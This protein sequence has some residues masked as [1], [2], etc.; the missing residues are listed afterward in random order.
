MAKKP[1]AKKPMAKKPA[2]KK[3]MAKT[4]AKK[5]AAKKP[6]PKAAKTRPAPASNKPRTPWFD[7][8]NQKPLISEYAQR[9]QPFLDS[10]ADGRIDD[11]ELEAQ[12]KRLTAAMRQVEPRLGGD[13]HDMVTRLLCEMAAYDLMQALHTMQSARKPTVF[14]G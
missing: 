5:P 8:A 3:P 10:M 9:L 13:L 4:A 2:A 11:G 6:A 1:A 7:A 14:Q 12:E